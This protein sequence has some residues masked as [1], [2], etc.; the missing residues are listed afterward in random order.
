MARQRELI[1]NTRMGW[2][3]VIKHFEITRWDWVSTSKEGLAWHK[4]TFFDMYFKPCKDIW[5]QFLFCS[6]GLF[7]VRKAVEKFLRALSKT[8]PFRQESVATRFSLGG[9]LCEYWRR[10][11]M[12][13]CFFSRLLR[14][15]FD[16]LQHATR[17]ELEDLTV[18]KC[19]WM[20]VRLDFS[21]WSPFFACLHVSRWPYAFFFFVGLL[22]V[23]PSSCFAERLVRNPN[24]CLIPVGAF[25]RPRI[26][27]VSPRTPW[28][29]L[30][31]VRS[32]H[33][34]DLSG[35]NQLLEGFW[36]CDLVQE[37]NWLSNVT[38]KQELKCSCFDSYKN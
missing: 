7:G 17:M 6:V 24:V 25:A 14:G 33:Y 23:P 16:N 32:L 38:T 31:T 20:E 35:W 2:E 30:F 27:A 15:R 22:A 21:R 5:C 19:L 12:G 10:Q 29:H 36:S 3:F 9:S 34:Q 1:E 28:T 37:R 4:R 18:P 8:C 13:G 26:T 11:K